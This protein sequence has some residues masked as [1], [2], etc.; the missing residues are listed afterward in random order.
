ME[1]LSENKGKITICRNCGAHCSSNYC[2]DC[3][4]SVLE[5]RLENKSFLI[6]ILSGISRINKGFLYTA[7]QLL[8]HPWKVVRDYIQ[9]RRIRYVAPISML[10]LVCF[11]SAFLGALISV[12]SHPTVS[13][14]GMNHISTFQAVI[15]YFGNIILNNALIQN[16]TIYIPALLAIPIVY[17][18]HG[19]MRFNMAEYLTAMIYIACSFLLFD[20]ITL[21]LSMLS[22]NL[23]SL[24]G[25]GYS[26]VV[27]SM[28]TFKAFP[29]SSKKARIGHFLLYI[30]VVSLI[31]LLFLVILGVS[32]GLGH[33]A[34]R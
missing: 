21:P 23:Y 24:V 32:I 26:L 28:C 10:I 18:S 29:L 30:L 22:D 7:G 11:I 4:Q 27:C 5:K 15:L 19:A 14:A 12:D 34:I 13:D 33:D 16:L 9:C 2:P 20:I 25:L 17:R 1:S 31:Y 6:G 3:G 8:V